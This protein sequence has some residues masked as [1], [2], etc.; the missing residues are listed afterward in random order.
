MDCSSNKAD[1]L[2]ALLDEAAGAEQQV[3]ESA[4]ALSPKA[5]EQKKRAL[6]EQVSEQCDVTLSV[7]VPLGQG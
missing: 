1:E 4:L 2:D 6:K 5:Q 7:L 3:F